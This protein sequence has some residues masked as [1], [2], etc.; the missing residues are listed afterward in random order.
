M[1]SSIIYGINYKGS[2]MALTIIHDDIKTIFTLFIKC[3]YGTLIRFNNMVGCYAFFSFPK[4]RSFFFS[5]FSFLNPH[6]VFPFRQN[7][8]IRSVRSV[9]SFFLLI[10]KT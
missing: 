8:K 5:R 9:R 7:A 4:G 3:I 10:L 2:M 1:V 6:F